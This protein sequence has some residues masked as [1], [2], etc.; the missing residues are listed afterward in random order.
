MKFTSL[1]QTWRTRFF[2]TGTTYCTDSFIKMICL[3]LCWFWTSLVIF[4]GASSVCNM[5]I[6]FHPLIVQ[7]TEWLYASAPSLYSALVLV[8]SSCPLQLRCLHCLTVITLFRNSS[9]FKIWKSRSPSPA[10]NHCHIFLN[11]AQTS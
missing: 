7:Y 9:S 6:C 1:F 11:T 3:L 4:R 8:H 5:Q 2:H 10:S